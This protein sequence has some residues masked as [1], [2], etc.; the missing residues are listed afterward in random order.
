M[1]LRVGD[2]DGAVGLRVGDLDDAVGLR[3]GDFDGAV[4]GLQDGSTGGVL[5]RRV[6]GTAVGINVLGARVVSGTFLFGGIEFCV[7]NV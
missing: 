3:V 2:L 4:V 6:V 5:G 7:E 1:G